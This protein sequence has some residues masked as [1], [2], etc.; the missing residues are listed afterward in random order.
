[1]VDKINTENIASPYPNVSP[2][3]AITTAEHHYNGLYNGHPAKLEYY[4]KPDGSVA[5]VHVVQIQNDEE[6]TW[7][8]VYVDAHSSNVPTTSMSSNLMCHAHRD[9]GDGTAGGH[10]SKS[11]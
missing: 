4:A 6:G 2:S 9:Y 3:R 10:L 8:E 1:M 7:V 11:Q 5:L